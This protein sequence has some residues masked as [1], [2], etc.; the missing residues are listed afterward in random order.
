MQ[1]PTDLSQY[2]VI[3]VLAVVFLERSFSFA[4]RFM[5]WRAGAED[6]SVRRAVAEIRDDVRATRK[7]VWALARRD[8]QRS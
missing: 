2:G 8:R 5:K 6:E 7:G 4:L 3:A 1:S